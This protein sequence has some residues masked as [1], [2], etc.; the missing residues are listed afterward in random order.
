[1]DRDS[2]KG[3]GNLKSL[4]MINNHIS[5]LNDSVFLPLEN[6][7]EL[8]LDS[9]HIHQIT[10]MSFLGP[11][12]LEILSIRS[13]KLL[14]LTHPV[15]M[16][17]H[18]LNR[19]DLSLNP[20]IRFEA[21]SFRNLSVLEELVLENLQLPTEFM[22]ETFS[23]L[24]NLQNLKLSFST[25]M[26]D[27]HWTLR[28]LDNLE[29]FTMRSSSLKTLPQGFL[30]KNCQLKWLDLSWNKLTTLMQYLFTAD[31]NISYID[32]SNNAINY[33]DSQA[34]AGLHYIDTVVMKGNKL[35]HPFMMMN[36][37]R[38][39]IEIVLP[40]NQVCLHFI[41]AFDYVAV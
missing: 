4:N 18:C 26:G 12:G 15:F 30:P 25:L 11:T 29:A 34:F 5:H 40:E 27:N 22:V 38:G 37:S 8:F 14:D 36:I 3:L 9:N 41:Y 24:G 17:L 13:N 10:Q 1:M 28:S 31:G 2:F 32:L 19:L 6:L 35:Y 23:W 21:H 33:V 39:P 16:D 7:I 20:I